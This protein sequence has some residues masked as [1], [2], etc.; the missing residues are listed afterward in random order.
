MGILYDSI[1]R[2]LRTFKYNWKSAKFLECKNFL[3]SNNF[4]KMSDYARQ[5]V[6]NLQSSKN[7]WT[8][9]VTLITK[10]QKCRRYKNSSVNLL[11]KIIICFLHFLIYMIFFW[12]IKKRCN[13]IL[14]L[15]ANSAFEQWQQE[16]SNFVKS[17]HKSYANWSLFGSCKGTCRW[18]LRNS[19]EFNTD[20]KLLMLP[21]CFPSKLEEGSRMEEGNIT[22]L[23]KKDDLLNLKKLPADYCHNQLTKDKRSSS[24]DF[25]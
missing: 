23:S 24:I 4:D 22:S 13:L 20:Y 14:S 6:N 25:Y 3:W 21:E 1:K 15:S 11:L 12:N 8:F 2:A 17:N 19:M 16:N 18:N 7:L 9:C 10:I 5:L